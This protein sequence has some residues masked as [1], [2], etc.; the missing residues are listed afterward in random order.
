MQTVSSNLAIRSVQNSAVEFSRRYSVMIS[1]RSMHAQ[2]NFYHKAVS[3]QHIV[4]SVAKFT[5]QRF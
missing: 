5:G 2:N 1:F 4:A 3:E